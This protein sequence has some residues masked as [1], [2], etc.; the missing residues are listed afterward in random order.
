MARYKKTY[1]IDYY[2]ERQITIMMGKASLNVLFSGGAST[3]YGNTPAQFTTSEPIFQHAI[4]HCPLFLKGG[5]KILSVIELEDDPKPLGVEESEEERAERMARVRA[6]KE[7][8]H[9]E[10]EQPQPTEMTEVEVTCIEDAKQYMMDN[11]G[12]SARALKTV[13]N[14]L[15]A[16]KHVGVRFK[17]CK[18]LEED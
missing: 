4:E 3:G 17:G 10:G 12:Y 16:A 14:I 18:E 11:H 13:K 15:D 6:A 7:T 1:G 5:I 9:D 8:A 2:A